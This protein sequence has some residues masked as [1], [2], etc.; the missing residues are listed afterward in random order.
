MVSRENR[1]SPRTKR[2]GKEVV[3]RVQ[4]KLVRKS[5][6]DGEQKEEQGEATQEFEKQEAAKKE[7]RRPRRYSQE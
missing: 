1:E 3:Q 4:P 5:P 2:K 6:E 7:E